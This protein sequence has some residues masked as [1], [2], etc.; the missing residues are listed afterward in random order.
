[1]VVEFGKNLSPATQGIRL[2]NAQTGQQMLVGV[3]DKFP[4]MGDVHVEGR[5]VVE[6]SVEMFLALMQAPGWYP[7]EPEAEPVAPG[8]GETP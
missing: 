6:V 5:R 4:I 1:M 8:E 7:V 3:I 2:V